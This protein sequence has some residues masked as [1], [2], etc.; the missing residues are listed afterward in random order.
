MTRS[1]RPGRIARPAHSRAVA[2]STS[3][4]DWAAKAARRTGQ[5][6]GLAGGLPASASTATG[7]TAYHAS[8]V[9]ISTRSG[10]ARPRATGM[11][12]PAASAQVTASGTTPSGSSNSIG[13]NT[14]WVGSAE[15]AP[16]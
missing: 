3:I 1:C 12:A 14:S 4:I 6:P 8:A 15:P 2:A 11:S 16:T 5:C 9:A 10:C 13:T 7:A